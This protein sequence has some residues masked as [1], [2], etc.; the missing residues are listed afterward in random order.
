MDELKDGVKE[1][2]HWEIVVTGGEDT[3]LTV[4]A[5]QPRSGSIKVLSVITD[6][7]SSIRTVTAVTRGRAQMQCYR[8][9]IGWDQQRLAPSCQVI[10]VASHRLD[11]QWEKRRNRHKTRRV[12]FRYMSVEV[13]EEKPDGVLLAMACS[14]GALRLFSVSEGTHQIDLL[15]ETFYHQRCVLSVAA[16]S[17]EDGEG[18]RYRLLFSAATD[19]RIAVWDLTDASFLSTG[20]QPIPCLHIH[21]HQSG[22]NSLAVWTEK[23]GL[24]EGGCLVTVASGGDDGQLTVSTIRVHYPEDRKFGGSRGSSQISE[25]LSPPTQ[26][27]LELHSQSHSPLAHAAPL[28]ALKLLSP[29]LLVSTSADQRVCLWRVC[30]TG[31][32]HIGALCSHVADAA[33]LAVWEGQLREEEEGDKEMK[34]SFESEQ[35]ISV[36][37]GSQTGFKKPAAQFSNEETAGE[38]EDGGAVEAESETGHL[39]CQ[40]SEEKASETASECSDQAETDRVSQGNTERG[41]RSEKMREKTGW[42]LL[43]GQGFQ[44]LRVP[45]TESAQSQKESHRVKV[46]LQGK[47]T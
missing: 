7:I 31:I 28:T 2:G 1:G 13:V 36:W 15:W 30:S 39:V 47:S 9:S 45:N 16:C 32:S 17:L 19:G 5:I 46:T 33:G 4:I 24:N 8:L 25:A 12:C 38:S 23:P 20:T 21:A 37:R 10:Q 41:F 44:L 34:T 42:V 3:S 27:H 26:L 18:H 14:D 43:C 22:I 29:G 40:T 11:E 35:E 6:H